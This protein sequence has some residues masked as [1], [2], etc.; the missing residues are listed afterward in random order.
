MKKS[1]LQRIGFL[2]IS[3]ILLG[4]EKGDYDLRSIAPGIDMKTNIDGVNRALQM[5]GHFYDSLLPLSTVSPPPPRISVGQKTIDL[6]SNSYIYIPFTITMFGAPLSPQV[7]VTAFN[8]TIKGATGY[9]KT[10]VYR[11]TSTNNSFAIGL[12][13]PKLVN[14][15]TFTIKFNADLAFGNQKYVTTTDSVGIISIPAVPCST[16]IRGKYG[17]LKIVKIDLGDKKGKVTLHYD[18]GKDPDRIDLRYGENFIFSTANKLLQPGRFPYFEL[19]GFVSTGDKVSKEFT[20]SY[21]PKISREVV[22]YGLAS[23]EY[24]NSEWEVTVDC[25]K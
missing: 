2:L 15:D 20:F 8:L 1:I 14:L 13:I 12:V 9:W 16:V 24:A 5:R 6:R 17:P 22:V 7:R 23:Q 25:V 10:P 21:D 4:C 11:D 3:A 19:G 18:T